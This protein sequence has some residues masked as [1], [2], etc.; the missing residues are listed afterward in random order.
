[1]SHIIPKNMKFERILFSMSLSG[2]SLHKYVDENSE[3]TWVAMEKNGRHAGSEVLRFENEQK[4]D[5]FMERELSENWN[6]GTRL[7]HLLDKFFGKQI[8]S[9]DE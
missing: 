9:D 8:L 6:N 1:M 5:E 7:A 3:K 2:L 4:Y